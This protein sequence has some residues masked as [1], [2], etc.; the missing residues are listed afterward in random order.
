MDLRPH[1]VPPASLT[2]LTEAAAA[3]T[4]TLDLESVLQ[5]IS[6]LACGVTRA[7]ASNVFLLDARRG[8]LVVAAATGHRR[9]GLVGHEFEAHLGIPGQVVRSGEPANII[10]VRANSKFCKEIDD[11]SSLR[12]RSLIAAPMVHRSEVIGVI[13]VV[14]RLDESVFADGDL[15]ILQIFATFAATATQNAR[16]HEDLKRRFEGLRD[17]V[18]KPTSII[19]DSPLLTKVLD[20]CSRVAPSEAT[21]LILGET[22]TGKELCARQIHRASRRRDGTFVAINCAALSET[23]LESELFGHEKG[24]F[25]GAHAQRPGWFELANEGTLFLDEIGDISRSTQAKLLRVLQE[26][27]FVRVGGTKSI[28]CNVRIIAATNRNLKNMMADGVFREDLYY[29]LS[30]FPLQVPALRERRQDIPQLVEHFVDRAV[31][32][33]RVPELNVSPSTLELL[34]RYDWPGNI[35]ELQNVIERSVLMSDGTVLL[36]CDLPPDIE[37]A[38]KVDEPLADTSTL[39]GQECNM[40]VKALEQHGWNQSQAAR[41]LGITRYHLR[42]RMKKYSIQKPAN[43][44]IP[45]GA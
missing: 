42:H 32:E 18:M 45:A 36:P 2:A 9:D 28:P 37:A 17:S 29:R 27:E 21:V 11:I 39:Q 24:A 1:A 30:V 44:R 40:I 34:T 13:E 20:L 41:T 7:E 33:F 5:T 19:G 22:G 6:R 35:R 15:K 4:S 8:K 14:N 38:V 10:D 26:K 12:T 31:R 43:A 16:T 3:I 23:L 25:T